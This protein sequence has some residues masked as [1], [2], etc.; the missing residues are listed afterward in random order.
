MSSL[1][2]IPPRS[3]V[4][5][6]LIDFTSITTN[7]KLHIYI[8]FYLSADMGMNSPLSAISRRLLADGRS[9]GS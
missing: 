7:T 4:L 8:E 9:V 1:G 5:I 6:P 2:S 3:P